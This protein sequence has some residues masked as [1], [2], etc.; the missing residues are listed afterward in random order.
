MSHFANDIL[1]ENIFEGI[2]NELL[3]KH[4]GKHPDFI[5]EIAERLT[6]ERLEEME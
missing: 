6:I 5:E 3:K 4:P 1:K 2:L